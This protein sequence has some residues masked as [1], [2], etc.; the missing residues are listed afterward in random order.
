M[1]VVLFELGSGGQRLLVVIHHLAVDG[2]SWRVI[3]EDLEAAYLQLEA[4]RAVRLPLK[5]TSY[6]HWAER[7]A[8]EAQSER[9]EQEVGYWLM[10][11]GELFDSGMRAADN[12]SS[13]KAQWRFPVDYPGGQNTIASAG[14]VQVRLSAEESRALVQVVPATYRTQINDVLL[15]ALAAA[16]ARWTGRRSLL[17]DV[18]GHGREDLFEDVDVS[19][20]VGWFTSLCPVRLRLAEGDVGASLKSI[21]EHLRSVP[22]RGI[23]YGLLRYLGRDDVRDQLSLG[24]R[25]QVS[26]NY[27]GQLDGSLNQSELLEAAAEGTGPW[28]GEGARDHLLEI[29]ARLQGGQLRVTFSYSRELHKPE[30]IDALA[31]GYLEALRDLIEHCRAA[32]A[33]G[34]TPSDFPLANLDQGMLDKIVQKVKFEGAGD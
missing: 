31:A 10:Q 11:T 27:L 17:V 33:G 30:T 18:E 26:F 20:T 19:R 3:L 1:R 21:K 15:T 16:F 5:T 7:L 32:E 23:G 12:R 34:Y 22:E 13:S 25:A 8:I 2:V 4:G 6:K 9:R 28:L 29:N 24:E 14:A